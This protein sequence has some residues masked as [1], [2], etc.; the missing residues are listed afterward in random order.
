M[1]SVLVCLGYFFGLSKSVPVPQ[2]RIRFLGFLSDSILQAFLIPQDK[3]IKFATLCDSILHCRTA[4][5]KTLHCFLGKVTSFSLAVLAA[6]LYTREVYRAI[7]L[8]NRSSLPIKGVGDFCS[9]I[10]HWRFLDSWSEHLPWMDERHLVVIVTSNASQYARGG[11]VYNPSGPPLETRD[12]WREDVRDKPI[13]VKE[14]L[15]LDNIFKAGKLVLSNCCVDAH[16]DC[17]A[18]IQAWERQGDKS[19]QL[20]DAL[21]ELFQ[22][23]LAQNISTCLQFVPPPLNQAN[24]LSRALSDKDCTLV[25]EPWKELEN[26]FGPHTFDLM[27]LDS[28]AQI[29]CSGSQ[30]PSPF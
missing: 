11:I 18:P 16:V 10:A 2:T 3:R 21:K 5:I 8:A 19:K 1:C 14:A 20:N 29:G 13:T 24:A 7:S 4:S 27:A 17:L 15:A 28:N 23:L 6:Q 12:I 25:P 26:L 30:L 9:N 22:T